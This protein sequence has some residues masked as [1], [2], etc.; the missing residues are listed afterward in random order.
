MEFATEIEGR[1]SN[2]YRKRKAFRYAVLNVTII[3]AV[4]EDVFN[5]DQR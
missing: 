5:N 3:A 4:E 2:R 1:E